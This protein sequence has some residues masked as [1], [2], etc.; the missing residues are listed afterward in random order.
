MGMQQEIEVMARTYA[1]ADIR[2][3]PGTDGSRAGA[4]R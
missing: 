4:F 2:C 1:K 3:M